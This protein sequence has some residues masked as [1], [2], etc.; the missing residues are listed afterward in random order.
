MEQVTEVRIMTG[1]IMDEWV[2]TGGLLSNIKGAAK[3]AVKAA[4]NKIRQ[5]KAS[6]ASQRTNAG[7]VKAQSDVDEAAEK[8]LA[9]KGKEE[10]AANKV[11]EWEKKKAAA[12]K[13]LQK[14][15]DQRGGG[16]TMGSVEEA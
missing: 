11:T 7:V 1:E 12:D 13:N 15:I 2:S 5:S 16:S 4:G 3:G 10:A 8:Q 6:N 14:A 9:W